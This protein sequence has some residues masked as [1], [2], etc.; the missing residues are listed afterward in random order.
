MA[1]HSNL[2]PPILILEYL[3]HRNQEYVV[4]HPKIDTMNFPFLLRN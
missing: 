2:E 3:V 1:L 4:F